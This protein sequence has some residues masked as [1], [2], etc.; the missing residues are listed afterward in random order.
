MWMQNIC[1]HLVHCQ[2]IYLGGLRQNVV[3]TSLLIYPTQRV[4]ICLMLH[5]EC[6]ITCLLTESHWIKKYTETENCSVLINYNNMRPSSPAQ[7][8][9]IKPYTT[10]AVPLHT[11]TVTHHQTLHYNKCIFLSLHNYPSSN[12]ITFLYIEFTPKLTIITN[13]SPQRAIDGC[14]EIWATI[15]V[16]NT[17]IPVISMCKLGLEHDMN[18]MGCGERRVGKWLGTWLWT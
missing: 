13:L 16:W 18:I 9:I 4:P 1:S 3:Y 8:P 14:L 11:C 17:S 15:N 10:I 2:W 6:G 7:L 12:L 5:L